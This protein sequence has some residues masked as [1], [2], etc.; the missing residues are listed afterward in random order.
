[1]FHSRFN[2]RLLIVFLLCSVGLSGCG[3]SGTSTNDENDEWAQQVGD[4][5]ASIDEMGGSSGTLSKLDP[6]YLKLRDRFRPRISFPD[7]ISSAAASSCGTSLT[8]GT[9]FVLTLI[10]TFNSCTVDGAAFSGS[11]SLTWAGAGTACA[12]NFSSTGG[13]ITR[14]PTYSVT[15][16]KSASLEVKVASPS[17]YGQRITHVSGSGSSAVFSFS[18]DGINRKFTD[19]FGST[20]FDFTSSTTSNLTVTGT[21][22]YPRLINGG[23]LHVVNNLNSVN[24]D[25]T[26]SSVAWSGTCNCPTSGSWSVSCS[27]GKTG[28]LY[29]NGCGSA[30]MT[31]GGVSQSVSFDRCYSI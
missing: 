3:L 12:I 29:L 2:T 11:V 22:R 8:F 23:P 26:A 20:A 25:F 30:T 24:C 28:S 5:M 14:K 21:S 19:S 10:R 4:V 9:C 17:N 15:G 6:S 18:S 13:N 7:L 27:D 16:L 31:L 1:M